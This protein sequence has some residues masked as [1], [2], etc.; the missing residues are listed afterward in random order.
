[1]R[2][3]KNDLVQVM[4]GAYKGKK[5]KILKVFF[6]K[7]KKTGKDKNTCIVETINLRIKH[8]KP[9]A[10]GEAS[11]RL[12]KECPIRADNL[13]LVCPRCGK[14]TKIKK[15]KKGTQNTRVCKKCNEMVDEK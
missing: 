13:R 2:L 4:I 15:E 9:T 12:K 3:K 1:M 10:P 11:G 7:D 6:T 8:Q 14:L 5:G